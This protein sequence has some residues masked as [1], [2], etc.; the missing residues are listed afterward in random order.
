MFICVYYL[1]IH[2]CI[3]PS[4][5]AR[6]RKLIESYCATNFERLG[7]NSCHDWHSIITDIPI[8]MSKG[9]KKDY[10]KLYAEKL[11][12]AREVG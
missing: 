6:R 10:Y 3:L 4:S 12:L 5:T 1:L 7:I 8:A 2:A 11:S 9:K